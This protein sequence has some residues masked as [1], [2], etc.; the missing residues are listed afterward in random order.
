MSAYPELE[1]NKTEN[2]QDLLEKSGLPEIFYWV[3]GI[4]IFVGFISSLNFGQAGMAAVF[5]GWA[6]TL[7]SGLI[8][9]GFGKII[10]LLVKS[11]NK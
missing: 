11:I 1:E 4:V 6:V 5:V 2:E 3:G 7:S 8:L 10:E 9:I